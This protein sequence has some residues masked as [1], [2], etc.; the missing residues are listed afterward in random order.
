[1]EWKQFIVI[2]YPEDLAVEE[3]HRN[4]IFRI[5]RWLGLRFAY[6]LYHLRMS[7][8]FI[9]VS[10]MFISIVGLYFLS[11]AIQ[12][13][14]LLP[15]I[16]A[17]LL[18]GQNI[19]DYADG[20]VARASGRVSKLGGVLDGIANSFSRGAILVLFGAFT[21]SIFLVVISAF[22]LFIL[23]NFR[24]E[25]GAKISNTAT[26]KALE[27]L[28]RISLSI[29]VMLFALPLF[30]AL[31]NFIGWSMATFSCIIVDSYAGL[32]ILWL[33]LCLW[34]KQL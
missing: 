16:G 22:S 19:L 15:F 6:L 3:S 34:K 20:A 32:A 23:I 5:Y 10:R 7:A 17:F 13:N 25:V 1:M 30:F 26:F 12:G 11:S 2:A 21:G 28:Y 9:S 18:Y 14:I 4:V 8:N 27:L 29:E 33:S 31:S 24:A